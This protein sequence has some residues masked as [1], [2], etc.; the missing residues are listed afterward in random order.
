MIS[1]TIKGTRQFFSVS[2]RETT[3]QNKKT[4]WHLPL[5][6]LWFIPPVSSF[7][8]SPG[9]PGLN[10]CSFCAMWCPCMKG[11]WTRQHRGL[12][13]NGGL[14]RMGFACWVCW[15][16]GRNRFWP[17]NSTPPSPLRT[18]LPS[19]AHQALFLVL[20]STALPLEVGS[21]TECLVFSLGF[22]LFRWVIHCSPACYGRFEGCLKNSEFL[23]LP[24]PF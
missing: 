18:E 7:W 5:P 8:P 16:E 1:Q 14:T 22:L 2:G 3:I 15:V 10:K 24:W 23:T 4:N 20:L 19:G 17:Q 11:W 21:G 13:G 12:T 9:S 6:L